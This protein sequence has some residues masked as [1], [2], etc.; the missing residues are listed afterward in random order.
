MKSDGYNFKQ[1]RESRG[2]SQNDVVQ[3]QISRVALS[4]FENSKT[5]LSMTN[6]KYILNSI[7]VS[8][9]E[10]DFIKNNYSYDEKQYIIIRFNQIFSNSNNTICD[11]L[12]SRCDHYLQNNFS[13]SIECIKNVMYILKHLN[14][15]SHEKISTYVEYFSSKIWN[16]L[17]KIDN[18]TLLDIKIIN[19][20]LHFFEPSTYLSISKLLVD[21][22]QKYKNFSNIILL[23]TSIYLNLSIL[24]LMENNID[25]AKYYSDISLKKAFNSKRIDYIAL[26][27][28][29]NG[30][31]SESENNINK[32]LNLLQILDDKLFI[33]QVKSEINYFKELECSK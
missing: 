19:C 21:N 24:F 26:S 28:I 9:E 13:V 6:F 18:W 12:I 5:N 32:G 16:D 25:M 4:K 14:Y 22:L 17:S 29:R 23:E 8:L 3:N 30:L 31:I 27:L 15:S 10:F 20:C 33:D 2:L 1:I 11:D 7:D